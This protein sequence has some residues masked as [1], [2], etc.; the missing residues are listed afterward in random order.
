M[1]DRYAGIEHIDGAGGDAGD[2]NRLENTMT[3]ASKTATE[4]ATKVAT[5]TG[6]VEHAA[7][8]GA[9]WDAFKRKNAN[10][11]PMEGESVEEFAAAQV[12]AFFAYC[13]NAEAAGVLA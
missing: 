7:T 8:M 3:A 12:E 6:S 2:H 11:K 13:R 10:V 4:L 1:V 9:L 5:L